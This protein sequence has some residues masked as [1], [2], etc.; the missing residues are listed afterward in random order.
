MTAAVLCV[1]DRHVCFYT[2]CICECVYT[3]YVSIVFF[4]HPVGTC[5]SALMSSQR[6]GGWGCCG[7]TNGRNMCTHTLNNICRHTSNHREHYRAVSMF[8]WTYTPHVSLFF[9]CL[10]VSPHY[11]CLLPPLP[12]SLSFSLVCAAWESTFFASWAFSP[13]LSLFVSFR[14]SAQFTWPSPH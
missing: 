11:L 12:L 10:L 13:S 7:G 1:P 14:I 6:N 5:C 8:P 4:L 2:T 3:G 9:H